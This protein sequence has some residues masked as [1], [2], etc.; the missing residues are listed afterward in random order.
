MQI[1][2]SVFEECPL[3]TH[4]RVFY[5]QDAAEMSI[6]S[7]VT[8]MTKNRGAAAEVSRIIWSDGWCV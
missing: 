6:Y 1:C 7:I 8:L 2:F 5:R 4:S 3:F